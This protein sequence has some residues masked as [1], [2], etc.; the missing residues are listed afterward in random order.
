MR[1]C[2]AA[3]LLAA[4]AAPVKAT[5]AP[6]TVQPWS[7]P[8]ADEP[9]PPA[10]LP[11]ATVKPE[12]CAIAD[13]RRSYLSGRW[14]DGELLAQRCL[15]QNPLSTEARVVLVRMYL[16]R[17]YAAHEPRWLD[18]ARRQLKMVAADPAYGDEARELT[19]LIEQPMIE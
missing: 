11:A 2:A 14:K 4:C 15:Q 17:A 18:E 3:L 12:P 8:L 13:L 6:A 1:V 10:P 9:T 7:L 19:T 5:S 16:M